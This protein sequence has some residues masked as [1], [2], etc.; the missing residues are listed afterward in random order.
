MSYSED[1]SQCGLTA[2]HLKI[3]VIKDP[4][5]IPQPGQTLQQ[6]TSESIKLH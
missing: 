3:N 4:G 2:E 5:F 6:A 1:G